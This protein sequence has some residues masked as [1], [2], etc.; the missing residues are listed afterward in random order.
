MTDSS[1]S[2]T[3]ILRFR[4]HLC[5]FLGVDLELLEH[6]AQRPLTTPREDCSQMPF[7]TDE[8][9][10]L[11]EM[12]LRRELIEASL[13]LWNVRLSARTKLGKLLEDTA[14]WIVAYEEGDDAAGFRLA[15]FTA[16]E[17]GREDIKDLIIPHP[18][19]PE[20]QALEALEEI[21]LDESVASLS[22]RLNFWR[23]HYRDPLSPL[24]LVKE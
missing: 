10:L 9:R 6:E 1:I 17:S 20:K 22:R 19:I 14:K 3:V 5:L 4:L 11:R 15:S 18:A 13:H 12:N 2:D 16:I 21:L 23:E 24:R 7:P 8:A